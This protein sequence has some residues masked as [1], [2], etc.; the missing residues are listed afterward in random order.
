[1]AVPEF[2]AFLLPTLEFAQDGAEHSLA[3]IREHLSTLFSLTPEDRAEILPSGRQRRFELSW[4]Q[5][6]VS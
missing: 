4:D 3:E 5:W 6:T 2:Q 1:M